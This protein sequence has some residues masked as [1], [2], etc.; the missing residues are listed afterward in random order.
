MFSRLKIGASGR[1]GRGV[2]AQL[3]CQ[4]E[5]DL[6]ST[7]SCFALLAL[8][9][10][11]NST[12]LEPDLRGFNLEDVLAI[13]EEIGE[14]GGLFG[15]RRHADRLR[16]CSGNQSSQTVIEI[17]E[18]SSTSPDGTE[19]APSFLKRSRPCCSSGRTCRR[20]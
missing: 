12:P 20:T 13:K 10:L 17:C 1:S 2:A 5:M 6:R 19:F 9:T 7:I 11:G 15:G 16:L 4:P 3:S 8:F 14:Q 18:T